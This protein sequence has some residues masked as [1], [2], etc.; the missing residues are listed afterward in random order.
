MKLN[1]RKPLVATAIAGGILAVSA[2][3]AY[4]YWTATGTGTGSATTADG[5]TSLTITQ[6]TFNGSALVPGGTAQA[7]SGTIA[8]ANTFA[9]PITSFVATVAVDSTHATAGCLASWYSVPTLSAPSS[10]PAGGNVA[11]SGTVKLTDLPTTNQDA[12][13]GAAVTLTYNA[14]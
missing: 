9:V 13:K 12:C 3:A 5:S 11:F 2:T 1:V 14:G 7:I 8:N 4:A 6:N 10:V